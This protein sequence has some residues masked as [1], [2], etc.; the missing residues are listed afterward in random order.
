ME[1]TKM[2]ELILGALAAW[3]ILSTILVVL[4]FMNSSRISK[5]EEVMR[6]K[7]AAERQDL[8]TSSDSWYTNIMSKGYSDEG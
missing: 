7:A 2:T 4:I 5:M 1:R 3:I 6:A 8:D